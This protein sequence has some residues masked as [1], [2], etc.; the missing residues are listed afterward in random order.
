MD[1]DLIE[2][3]IK[4]IIIRYKYNYKIINNNKYIQI[5]FIPTQYSYIKDDLYYNMIEE[6]IYNSYIYYNYNI[7]LFDCKIIIEPV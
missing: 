2:K 7:R 3:N 1:I 4:N 6:I 5:I